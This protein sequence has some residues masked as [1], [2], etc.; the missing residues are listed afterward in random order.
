MGCTPLKRRSFITF[1]S[2]TS[3][4]IFPAAFA[5]ILYLSYRLDNDRLHMYPHSLFS[6]SFVVIS[7][8]MTKVTFQRIL[9]LSSFVVRGL[10]ARRRFDRLNR[11]LGYMARLDGSGW[12]RVGFR[13]I[14]RNDPLVYI[15][16][17]SLSKSTTAATPRNLFF[18]LPF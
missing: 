18:F 6:Y 13:R 9:R 7:Q 8:I 12:P 4:P 10:L 11:R 15:N 1:D 16:L 2:I 17:R 14:H 5:N 3:W